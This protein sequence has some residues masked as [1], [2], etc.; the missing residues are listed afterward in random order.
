MT[1]IDVFYQGEGVREIEHLELGPDHTFATL[2]AK[3]IERHGLAAE[4]LIFLE[5]SDEPVNELLLV[6]EHVGPVVLKV[7]VHRCRH[8]EVGVTFN[9]ETVHHRFGP[10]TTIARVKRW[11][12]EHKFKMSPEEASEHVLQ[13]KGTHDRP[14]PGTHLGTLVTC[15]KCEVAFDLV[16]DQ[17]VNGASGE[18]NRD[19]A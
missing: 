15:P 19:R 9:N 2:K 18:G 12:A 17:R 16:P 11:A 8:V 6:T 14:A 4:T 7:H 10:G 3:L 13:I 5:D 1:Q